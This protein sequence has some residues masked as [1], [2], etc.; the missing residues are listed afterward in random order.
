MDW[1]V[2]KFTGFGVPALI[3][4]VA[5]DATGLYGAAAITLALSSIGPFGMLGGMATLLIAGL[6]SEAIA[7]YG[8]DYT[9]ERVLK[10]LYYDGETK[11]SI[12]KKIQSSHV[13]D[14]LKLKL[15][16]SIEQL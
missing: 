16:V 14:E 8:F 12:I 15:Y 5:I 13:S 1:L 3:L 10:K 4:L 7:K 9:F 2:E 6:A 11:E